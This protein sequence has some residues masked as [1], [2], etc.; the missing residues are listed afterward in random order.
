MSGTGSHIATT[1]KRELERC[2]ECGFTLVYSSDQ[3]VCPNRLCGVYGR[4]LDAD[5]VP[6][7]D[8]A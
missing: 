1:T 8:T 5:D 6:P 7:E 3:L 2:V 4:S